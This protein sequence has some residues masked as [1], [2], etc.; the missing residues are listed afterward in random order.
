MCVCADSV[1]WGGDRALDSVKAGRR[2]PEGRYAVG[3]KARGQRSVGEVFAVKKKEEE[4][5]GAGG[6]A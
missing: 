1:V 3:V 4:A 2:L 6:K 5:E